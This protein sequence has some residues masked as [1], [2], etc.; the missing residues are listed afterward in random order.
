VYSL[1]SH[2]IS[3]SEKTGAQYPQFEEHSGW[4]PRVNQHPPPHHPLDAPYTTQFHM[5]LN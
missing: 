5:N 2:F 1:T 3:S 4:E